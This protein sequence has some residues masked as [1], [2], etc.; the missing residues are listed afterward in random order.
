MTPEELAKAAAEAAAK[1][2]A[3]ANA[4]LAAKAKSLEMLYDYTKFHIGVYLTLTASYITVA[5]AKVGG[6]QLLELHPFFLW[7]AVVAFMVAGFAGG[8]IVS[9]LT[10]RI[11][12]S[13]IDF[14]EK[15]I[16]P[17]NWKTIHGKA[18]KWTYVEHTS[19]WI[20]LIS[21][22]LSFVCAGA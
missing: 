5:T 4:E 22:F 11:G 8:V 1:A 10:Q 12:G 7:L 15:K 6:S 2:T 20:G 16:G 14:L 18:R 21:A 9:S 3:K 19:F 13:S 17:W